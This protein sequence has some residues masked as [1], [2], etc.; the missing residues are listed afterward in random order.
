M[1]PTEEPVPTPKPQISTAEFQKRQEELEKRARELDRREEE[2]RNAP[3]NSNVRMNNWPPLPKFCPIQPCFYQDINVDIPVEFQQ[4]VKYVYY[5]WIGHT[6]LRF[7][8][9]LIGLLYLFVGGDFGGT[10]I[11]AVVMFVAF[12]PLSYLAWFRPVYKAFRDDSSISFMSFFFVFFFQMLVSILRML[13]WG[14]GS[15]GLI[16][17]FETVS[18]GASGGKIFVGILMIIDGVGFG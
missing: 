3:N 2:L 4:I 7:Y 10:F 12:T 5:L 9:V 13:G 17:G 18:A 15:S 16:L 11:W 1:N 6:A 8:N 14:S